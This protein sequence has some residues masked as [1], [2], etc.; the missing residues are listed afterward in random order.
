M[1]AEGQSRWEVRHG[2]GTE[3]WKESDAERQSCKDTRRQREAGRQRA[4]TLTQRERSRG[5]DSRRQGVQVER[6]TSGLR[7]GQRAMRRDK[8]VRGAGQSG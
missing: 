7:Q 4:G 3:K 2:G 8:E 5:K 1:E 6:G